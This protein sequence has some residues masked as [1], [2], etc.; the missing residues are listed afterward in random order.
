MI[1]IMDQFPDAWV[2]CQK[3][4]PDYDAWNASFG[5]TSHYPKDGYWFPFT[6]K[7]ATM[8]PIY[9]K[10]ERAKLPTDEQTRAAI[11]AITEWRNQNPDVVKYEEQRAAEREKAARHDNLVAEIKE[12]SLGATLNLLPGKKANASY[13]SAHG[14]PRVNLKP[15]IYNSQGVPV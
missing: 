9:L 1:R 7:I 5:T 10:T 14:G 3:V 6:V 11:W 8:H 13:G 15:K 4:Q 12:G 2:V